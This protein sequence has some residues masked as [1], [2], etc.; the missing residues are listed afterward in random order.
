[1]LGLFVRGEERGRTGGGGGRSRREGSREGRG[2]GSVFEWTCPA[3]Y[4]SRYG[5]CSTSKR[6]MPALI[7][8]LH[9][10]P[11]LS[12]TPEPPQPYART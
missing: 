12:P 2:K 4:I 7:K 11:P 9:H 3:T 10:I 6:N 1:M 8:P 5:S